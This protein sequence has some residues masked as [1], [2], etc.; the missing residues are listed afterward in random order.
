MCLPEAC[1]DVQSMQVSKMSKM[2]KMLKML[3]MLKLAIQR[4]CGMKKKCRKSK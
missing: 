3:R 2:S 4:V 1:K